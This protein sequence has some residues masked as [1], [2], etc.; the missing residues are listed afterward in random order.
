MDQIYLNFHSKNYEVTD[1]KFSKKLNEGLVSTLVKPDFSSLT[2]VKKRIDHLTFKIPFL[3]WSDDL[4]ELTKWDSI[5]EGMRGLNI[6]FKYLETGS[7]TVTLKLSRAINRNTCSLCIIYKKVHVHEDFVLTIHNY[8]QEAIHRINDFCTKFNVKVDISQLKQINEEY[9]VCDTPDSLKG[10]P[11]RGTNITIDESP[12]EDGEGSEIEAKNLQTAEYIEDIVITT[13]KT[14]DD[15]M[16]VN[17]LILNSDK[18][19]KQIVAL[20]NL[21]DHEL[22]INN[23]RMKHVEKKSYSPDETNVYG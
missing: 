18:R 16:N 5:T 21:H 12:R 1:K 3:S 11:F 22:T 4:F 8:K 20:L 7:N 17:E 13:D 15:I 9:K 19:Q 10:I 23:A 6:Y 2:L 14:Q